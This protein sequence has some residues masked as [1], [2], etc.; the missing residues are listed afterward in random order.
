MLCIL[1]LWLL[2]QPVCAESPVGLWWV[3]HGDGAPLQVRLYADGKA[4]SDYS[5]NNPGRWS[6]NRESVEC[7]WADGWKER[8]EPSGRVWKKFG[9]KPGAPLDGPASNSSHAYQVCE[10]PDGWFGPSP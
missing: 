5:S 3:S 9:F 10:S 8:F 7:L 2:C 6:Q 1:S 4:W